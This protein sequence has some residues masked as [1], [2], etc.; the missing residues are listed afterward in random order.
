MV[1]FHSYV[2]LPEGKIMVNQWMHCFL[3]SSIFRHSIFVGAQMK[4]SSCLV[5]EETRHGCWGSMERVP[6]NRGLM[7]VQRLVQAQVHGLS[8]P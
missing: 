3:Y 5:V 2:S 6:E 8:R 4:V 7:G 1:I